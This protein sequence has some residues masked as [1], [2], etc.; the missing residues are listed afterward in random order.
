MDFKIIIV[1]AIYEINNLFL[2]TITFT[3]SNKLIKQIFHSTG[4]KKIRT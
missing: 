2:S 1:L 4:E 3:Y